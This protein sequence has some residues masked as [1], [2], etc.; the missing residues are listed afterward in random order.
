[1]FRAV[2]RAGTT[3]ILV[4]IL[5]ACTSAK[6]REFS[7]LIE[8]ARVHVSNFEYQAA[9]DVYSKALEVKED[10]TVRSELIK[11]NADIKEVREVKEM[12]SDLQA[13]AGTY[14]NVISSSDLIEMCDELTKV[15]NSIDSF[16]ASRNSPAAKYI[17]D[18]RKSNRYFD[19]TSSIEMAR[20]Y[21][22]VEGQ[23]GHDTFTDAKAISDSL[24]AL[25]ASVPVPSEFGAIN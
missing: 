23:E 18:M 10:A 4:L 20:I 15:V 3:L 6:D 13:Y 11:I 2:K 21:R 19:F 22:L 17:Q 5:S 9:A 14:K 24:D 16:D 25:L 12:T 1:M 8:Q 7:D